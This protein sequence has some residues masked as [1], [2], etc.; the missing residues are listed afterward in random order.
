MDVDVLQK[1]TL[2]AV[3]TRKMVFVMNALE[4]GWSVKKRGDHFI[5][6][7]KHNGKT[8]ILKEEYLE[9]FL[10]QNIVGRG[11]SYDP[12]FTNAQL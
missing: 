8:E 5:F 11:G 4:K 7:K 2:T 10:L 6:K 1:P 3:D 12:S 9:R